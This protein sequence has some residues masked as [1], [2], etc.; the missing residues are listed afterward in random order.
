V[1][2]LLNVVWFSVMIVLFAR[3]MRAARS[4]RFQRWLKAVTG[5]V[6]VAFGAKLAAL[7]P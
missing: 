1:H 5:I 7:N 2:A 3:V 4:G 6:F